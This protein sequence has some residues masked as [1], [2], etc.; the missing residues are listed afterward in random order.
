MRDRARL[1]AQ[2]D[3]ME[4]TDDELE[5]VAL[6]NTKSFSVYDEM[7]ANS[8]LIVDTF[9]ASANNA[10][11]EAIRT[12]TPVLVR[13][14][15]AHIE[16]LGDNYP[17]LFDD[18]GALNALFL[19]RPLLESLALQAHAHLRRMDKHVF[20]F[21]HFRAGVGAFLGNVQSAG[22]TPVAHRTNTSF[23][24]WDCYMDNYFDLRKAF[25]SKNQAA[26]H[27]W[28]HGLSEGRTCQCFN[29]NWT[30]YLQRYPEVGRNAK[31]A[32]KHWKR[33]GIKESRDCSCPQPIH[34][35]V[36]NKLR[37]R[38]ILHNYQSLIADRHWPYVMARYST[39]ALP[40]FIIA[41]LVGRGMRRWAF[42]FLCCRLAGHR[43]RRRR[44]RRPL[45]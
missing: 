26:S 16:Y 18:M 43:R 19:N 27:F 39:T 24:D 1:S 10:L 17:L 14:L 6:K 41:A 5:S 40:L 28:T 2:I 20:S 9:D 37:S 33:Y 25:N 8:F 23:C 31:E 45:R 30:C 38:L 35:Q 4:I 36:E 34:R 44:Q 3:G 21:E 29:C 42:A 7:V 32:K 15:P 22:F 13:N 12:A 11:L